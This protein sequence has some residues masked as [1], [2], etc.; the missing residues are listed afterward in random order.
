MKQDRVFVLT[1]A[2]ALIVHI[3]HPALAAAPPEQTLAAS[4]TRFGFKLLKKL[5]AKPGENVFISPY[6]VSTALEMTWN[7][8]SGA[9]KTSMANVLEIRGLTGRQVNTGNANLRASLTKADPKVSLTIANSLWGQ[10]NVSFLPA[11]QNACNTYYGADLRRVDFAQP[12]ASGAINVWVKQKTRGR[13]PTIVGRLSP[14]TL[15]VLVNAIHFHGQWSQKFNKAATRSQPFHLNNGQTKAVP[16][17]VRNGSYRYIRGDGF[18][19]VRLPYGSGRMAMYLAVPDKTNGLGSWMQ[20][21]DAARFADIRA[22]MRPMEGSVQ[23][24]RFRMEYGQSLLPTLTAMG[25]NGSNLRAM[26]REPAFISDVIHKTFVEVHEEG[27]E[28]A[29]STAVVVARASIQPGFDFVA[30]RPFFC[31]IRDDTTGETLFLGTI[32]NP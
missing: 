28:A 30:D 22:K 8:A 2:F 25:M 21:M 24:P 12:S 3:S 17:M 29:A 6:S 26:T 32:Y 5:A 20:N 16:M 27:T 9:S 7:G 31:A 18:Q 15:M 19:M 10:Q 1:A 11:F 13:I 4:H 23:I 14:N